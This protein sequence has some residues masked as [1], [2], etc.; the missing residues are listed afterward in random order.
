[1]G[2]FFP[3]LYFPEEYFPGGYFT[4]DAGSGTQFV[5]AALVVTGSGSA[6]FTAEVITS[7]LPATPVGGSSGGFGRMWR[8]AQRRRFVDAS[9]V[10]TARG[11]AQFT[12]RTSVRAALAVAG[13]G[14]MQA[15]AVVDVGRVRQESSTM[16]RRSEAEFWLLMAA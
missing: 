1:M 7:Q 15:T 8:E 14:T 10:A 11:S 9:L 6:Y 12:A 3:L 13:Q 16:E 5:D 4:E 2:E